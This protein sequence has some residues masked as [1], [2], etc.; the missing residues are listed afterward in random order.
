MK[1]FCNSIPKCGSY[2]LLRAVKK[3]KKLQDYGT[4]QAKENKVA[5]IRKMPENSMLAGHQQNNPKI[6]RVLLNN[7]VTTL[8]IIR[9]PR[10]MIVSRYYFEKSNRIFNRYR[11]FQTMPKEKAYN[12]IIKSV[13]GGTNG[14]KAKKFNVAKYIESFSQYLNNE[15]ITVIRFEDLI[16]LKG[17]GSLAAQKAT[18]LTIKKAI[19]SDVDIDTIANKVF[20]EKSETFRKGQINQWSYEFSETNKRLF[21]KTAG[22][23]LGKLGYG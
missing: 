16:G 14:T 4:I 23:L 8:F 1:V 17:G 21:N 2:L 11:Q 5:A 15:A 13:L 22:N 18:L 19:N 6:I 3:L 7:S 10:D 9:D 12:E 20:S